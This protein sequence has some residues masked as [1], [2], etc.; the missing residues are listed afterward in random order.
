MKK[1]FLILILLMYSCE[2]PS[3]CAEFYFSEKFLSIVPATPG[4][5]W[6]YFDTTLHITDTITLLGQSLFFEDNCTP[7]HNPQEVLKQVYKSSFF[8]NDTSHIFTLYGSGQGDLFGNYPIGI[9]YTVSE[10]IDSLNTLG[11]IF[12]DI[13]LVR[14]QEN[15]FYWATNIGLIRRDFALWNTPDTTYSFELIEYHRN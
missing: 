13:S 9:Y 4:S 12:N 10:T 14:I 2:T 8:R 6:I 11:G 15:A 3:N 7:S 5:Y 1:Y